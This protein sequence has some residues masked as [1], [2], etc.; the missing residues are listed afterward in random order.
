MHICIRLPEIVQAKHSYVCS[1]K[2]RKQ[3]IPSTPL[4]PLLPV[5][6]FGHQS[7]F[8]PS[9]ATVLATWL[10]KA[11]IKFVYLM[12]YINGAIILNVFCMWLLIFSMLSIISLCIY[13]TIYLLVLL[14]MNIWVFPDF[15]QCEHSSILVYVLVNTFAHLFEFVLRLRILGHTIR[16]YLT[17]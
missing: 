5:V 10:L 12:F 11:Q 8:S 3:N 7:L 9:I 6:F 14:L 13:T 15:A 1:P 17:Q 16:M 2:T 4:V